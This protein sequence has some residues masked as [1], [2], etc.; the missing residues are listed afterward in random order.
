VFAW[1]LH[2]SNIYQ[3]GFG[4]QSLPRSF[5]TFP[6]YLSRAV[7]TDI[8]NFQGI[9]G[10]V[11]VGGGQLSGK[12]FGVFLWPLAEFLPVGKS[13]GVYI[14][15]TLAGRNSW[16]VGPSLIGDAYVNFGL[17]GTVAVLGV[18]G[19]CLRLLYNKFVRQE[20]RPVVYAIVTVY[21]VR[22]MFEAINKWVELVVV[23]CFTIAVIAVSINA[24][25]MLNRS[26]E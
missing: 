6:A 5:T 11:A 24:K 18:F 16:G 25:M 9:A 12:T 15:Q 7:F 22:I 4:F 23:F 17:F 13:T 8:G 3:R 1:F 21:A 2:L 14:V 19:L 10:S 26:Q 20:I